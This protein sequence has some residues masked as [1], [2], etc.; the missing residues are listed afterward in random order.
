MAVRLS[1]LRAGRFLPPGR[2]LVLISVRGWVDPRAIVRLEGLKK[3]TLSGTWTGDLLVC[4]IVPQPTT[5]PRGPKHTHT[6]K[7]KT[8]QGNN[9]IQFNSLLFMCRVNSQKAEIIIIIQLTQIKV[10]SKIYTFINN[11]NN[12]NWVFALFKCIWKPSLKMAKY[13]ET[14]WK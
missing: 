11:I 1:A 12:N 4:S 8:K 2:F 5:L 6:N 9:S 3:S 7:T 14:W 10:K 13:V